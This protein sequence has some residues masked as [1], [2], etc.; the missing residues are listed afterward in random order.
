MIFGFLVLLTSSLYSAAP[1][2]PALTDG[3][4]PRAS[5]DNVPHLRFSSSD[6]R[7]VPVLAGV[8]GALTRWW[9]GPKVNN[10]DEQEAQVDE[11]DEQ[12]AQVDEKDEQEAQV[13]EK[14]EQEAQLA[15]TPKPGAWGLPPS[16]DG[17]VLDFDRFDLLL[18]KCSDLIEIYKHQF[19]DTYGECYSELKGSD[20]LARIEQ[21]I[22]KCKSVEDLKDD[23]TFDDLYYNFLSNKQNPLAC[24]DDK[25]N[26]QFFDEDVLRKIGT[27]DRSLINS[28]MY[29]FICFMNENEHC[30]FKNSSNFTCLKNTFAFNILHQMFGYARKTIGTKVFY[31]R[32]VL[33]EGHLPVAQKLWEVCKP[34][35]DDDKKDL[36]KELIYYSSE[37]LEINL[38]PALRFIDEASL[39]EYK[40][41]NTDFAEIAQ[42]SE[43]LEAPLFSSINQERI[44]KLQK[45]NDLSHENPLINAWDKFRRDFEDRFSIEGQLA[46]TTREYGIK[47]SIHELPDEQ[48]GVDQRYVNFVAQQP[49]QA[50]TQELPTFM[51][52][53]TIKVDNIPSW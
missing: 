23:A 12:E 52:P 16:V 43:E 19:N 8:F 3:K 51:E 25:C 30:F 48:P 49:A 35:N 31:E 38:I 11:K 9:S 32:T 4:P 18:K 41:L 33:F 24:T 34:T 36:I 21:D 46:E 7:V 17:R 14:D 15:L 50:Q 26:A 10:Q 29:S 45:L 2:R 22:V 5:V 28:Y 37:D 40:K 39:E 13:D 1:Q 53:V 6:N 47:P 42:S 27:P 20:V 44:K